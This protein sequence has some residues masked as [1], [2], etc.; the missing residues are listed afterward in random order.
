M[1]DTRQLE[2]SADNVVRYLERRGLLPGGVRARV[3]SLGGG[4]S[5]HVV[6]VSWGDDCVVVKQPLP[7]LAVE[8]DWPADVERVHNE[9]A[10]ARTY[11]AAVEAAGLENV[12]VPAVVFEDDDEHVVAV[13]CAPGDAPTWKDEL[14]DGHVDVDV[15]A[16]VG[17]ALGAVHDA[18]A[19]DDEVRANFESK[20]PFD[21]LRIDPYHRTTARRHPDVADAIHA[22]IRRV[23]GVERTL[24]HGD[25][26]PKNVLVDRSGDAP[27][28]WIIDFE[29]AHW[30]DPA[31][32]TAFMLNHL[33]IKSVY[34][35]GKQASYHD[36]AFEFWRAYADRVDWDVESSTVAELGVLLLARV[37]GKSPVE[38]V[39]TEA[40]ADALRRAA[41]RTLTEDVTTL[42]GFAAVIR[43]ETRAR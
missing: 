22:E 6:E 4:V 7:N 14:L 26:S 40:T 27:E 12:H 9:A 37:D 13:E 36:A 30:G 42:D 25:Y 11:A 43:E 24:V 29:V 32:D 28:P 15:A 38:Y 17:R 18:A 39:Q 16:E 2:L 41:R 34:N 33:F 20:R 23:R 31:F 19:G 3:R 5:N 1:S 10:A 35:H 21:Q 8:D